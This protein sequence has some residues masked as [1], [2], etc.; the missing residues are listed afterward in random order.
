MKIIAVS[1]GFDPVHAGHLRMFEEAKRL[2]DRL[3]VI[4]NNDAWLRTKKGKPFMSQEERAEI[5]RGFRCVDEV[6]I[7]EHAEDDTDRSVCRALEAIRPHIFANGGDRKPDGDPVPEETLCK[8][9][10]ISMV[11]NVGGDKIQSSSWLIERVR[12]E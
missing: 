9:L 3:I 1:G 4:L 11:Y 6:L 7:T 2:G 5:I 8:K 12:S 10:G